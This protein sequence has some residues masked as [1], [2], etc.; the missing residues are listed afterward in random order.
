[1]GFSRTILY[2]TGIIYIPLL[3]HDGVTPGPGIEPGYPEETWVRA[4][5]ATIAQSGLFKR[6][7]IKD[8]KGYRIK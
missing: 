1:M 7:I 4:T 3:S 8:L 6:T 5:R 2:K